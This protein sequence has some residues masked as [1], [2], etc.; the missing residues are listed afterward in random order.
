MLLKALSRLQ[1]SKKIFHMLKKFEDLTQ[2]VAHGIADLILI[3]TA[4]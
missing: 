1:F 2:N 3:I 4:N